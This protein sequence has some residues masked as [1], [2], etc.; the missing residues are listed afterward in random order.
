MKFT[1]GLFILCQLWVMGISMMGCGGASDSKS[2]APSS[3]NITTLIDQAI[4][5]ERKNPTNMDITGF[6]EFATGCQSTVQDGQTVYFKSEFSI[7]PITQTHDE[8]GRSYATFNIYRATMQVYSDSSCQI[9]LFQT[10]EDGDYQ[11]YKNRSTLRLNTKKLDWTPNRSEV[12]ERFNK[13]VFCSRTNWKLNQALSVMGTEC[14]GKASNR[15]TLN[16]LSAD[17]STIEIYSCED[18]AKP[19]DETCMTTRFYKI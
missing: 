15:V 13:D 12:A 6:H 14:S 16:S 10:F 17:D 3:S 4:G 2:T 7:Y 9:S 8:R 5:L 1:N 11:N 19:T 18:D